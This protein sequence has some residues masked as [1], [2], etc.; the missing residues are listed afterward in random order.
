[1]LEVTK[2][3]WKMRLLKLYSK[4][5]FFLDKIQFWIATNFKSKIQNYY[6][7]AIDFDV[8]YEF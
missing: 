6:S 5:N 7:T 1:M 8:G 4:E 2:A 3:F